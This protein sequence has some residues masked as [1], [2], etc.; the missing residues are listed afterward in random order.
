[1]ARVSSTSTVESEDLSNFHLD[2]SG[3]CSLAFG[4]ASTR[5][6]SVSSSTSMR[7][8]FCIEAEQGPFLVLF[9]TFANFPIVFRICI[10]TF[11]GD[12]YI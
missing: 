6:S 4:L 2:K 10:P 1:M 3:T 7:S 9:L 11:G 12:H 8:P 5:L